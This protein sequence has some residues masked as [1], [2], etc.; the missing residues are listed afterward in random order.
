MTEHKPAMELRSEAEKKLAYLEELSGEITAEDVQKLVHELRV[1]QIELEMQN[2]QLAASQAEIEKSR[3]KYSDLFDFAPVGYLSIDEDG[4]ILEANLAI[5]TLLGTE[6]RWMINSPFQKYIVVAD[7]DAFRLHLQK[8]SRTR[9]RDKCEVKLRARDGH[10][11]HAQ[12]HSLY[13][14]ESEG[15]ISYRTAV[16]DITEQQKMEEELRKSHDEL[17]QRVQERTA[18]LEITMGKLQE[19]NQALQDFASIASHDM[20]EPL[21]KVSS[22][23]NRIKLK[24]G[25]ALGEEGKDY[26]D[27]MLNATERMQSLLKSLLDYSRVTTKAEPFRE[28]DLAVI[29]REVLSDLEVRIER[30]GGE[31]HVGELP[32][33]EADPTQMRQLFQ[34]LIGNALKFH[35]QGE[36]PIV[37]VLCSDNGD[38]CYELTIE[39]NGIGFDEKCLDVIFAPFHR[40]HGR[41][42]YEG[43]GMGLAISRKMVERHG[44]SITAKSA[45]GKGSTFIVTLPLSQPQE[46]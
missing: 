9:G 31:V 37:R 1:H 18:E 46:S 8:I 5:A 45:P 23:G 43:T 28:V 44:G 32:T 4:L 33:V 12:V 13:V 10:E 11:P 34:N 6:R 19:S 42:T 38:G 36:K 15:K 40:L 29:V 7:R 26:L 3:K 30:T 27:R 22:F 20:Q 35:K 39:D 25:D 24:H 21:R 17:E 14:E 41:N 2:A 16:T